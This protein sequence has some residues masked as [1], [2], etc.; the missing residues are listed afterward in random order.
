MKHCHSTGAWRFLLFLLLF[1]PAISH[2]Q[3][4]ATRVYKIVN[5]ETGK[6]L[7]IN[8]FGHYFTIYGIQLTDYSGSAS[9]Q[10]KFMPSR[11]NG[12]GVYE[13]VNRSSGK[14]LTC[15]WGAGSMAV[16]NDRNGVV[17]GVQTNTKQLWQMRRLTSVSPISYEIV[18]QSPNAWLTGDPAFINA[19]TEDYQGVNFQSIPRG[20]YQIWDVVDVSPNPTANLDL[21]AY[22]I[23]NVRSTYLL[24][25]GTGGATDN[26][27]VASMYK[28]VQNPDAGIAGQEW[29]FVPASTPGYFHIINRTFQLAL[30]IG[31]SA[32]QYL[33]NPGRQ[34]NLWSDWGGPNQTWGLFDV[35]DGHLLTLAEARD[36]RPCIL[37][38]Y[39]TS[40]CLEM[41]GGGS[42]P[43]QAGRIP[44]QWSYNGTDNQM[45]YI[46]YRTANRS[47]PQTATGPTP[48]NS[49]AE[50]LRTGEPQTLGLL[51][52]FPNPAQTTV[53]VTLPNGAEATSVQVSDLQ[54]TNM[55][56]TIY[57]GRG[58]L[59]V[60][61]LAPG[62]YLV[63]A[64]DGKRTYRQKLVK[65]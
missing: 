37:W 4:N 47:A 38:N 49:S 63:T 13:I 24:E 10:W 29:R 35:Y 64:S 21:G 9:Q 5:H 3:L 40:Q 36:G 2:A 46:Q 25:G 27:G 6:V 58:Q 44:N 42:Y 34:A 28:V 19:S 32:L 20:P 18:L 61:G 50:T 45:W 22:A 11:A 17:N 15:P 16:Q 62:I 8:Y 59:D 31:G 14:V 30:E 33:Y 57:R 56:S 54:G 1:A 39:H 23:T 55:S 53:A 41:G 7:D 43:L 52:L 26:Y 51:G 65:N 60:A 48:V 12:T